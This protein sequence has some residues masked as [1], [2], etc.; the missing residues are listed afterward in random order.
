MRP[1]L[2]TGAWSA[3]AGWLVLVL[4]AHPWFAVQRP[5]GA[6]VLVVEGWMHRAGLEQAARLFHEGG[7]THLFVTGGR[8]PFAYYLK[9]GEGVE[10]GA[11][12]AFTGDVDLRI[13]GLPGSR[14]ALVAGT[15][16]LLTGV[17][18]TGADDRHLRLE[19]PVSALRVVD[20]STG[21]SG[22]D[23]PLLFVGRLAIDGTDAHAPP[24]RTRLLMADGTV[25]PG[26][27]TRAEEAMDRLAEHGVPADRMTAVPNMATTDRTFSSAA[28]F[29][30]HARA[31]GITAYDVATLGV[32]ARRT[33]RA[34]LRALGVPGSVGVIAL[35]DPWCGRWTWWTNHYGWYQVLKELAAS[36]RDLS[37]RHERP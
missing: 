16:T 18:G 22:A 17:V 25:R 29:A 10:V 32:H 28:T 6:P 1:W 15:D 13:D 8:R 23:V 30:A 21:S 20:R 34:H 14:W 5:V 37:F 12:A 9:R 26:R 27:P 33:H 2:R 3:A 35:P 36:V 24:R 11:E 19:R 31:H 4:F 7:Y